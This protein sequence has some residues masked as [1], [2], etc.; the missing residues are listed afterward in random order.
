M[1][2]SSAAAGTTDIGA[3]DAYL[4]PADVTKHTNLVNI[5][6][7]VAALMVIYHVPGVSP[8]THLRLNGKV[9]AQIFAGTIT[10][11]NDPAIRNLNPGS[12][13]RAP[14]SC[15]STGPTP[16]AARSCSPRT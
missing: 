10:T 7:A 6:L 8:S 13:C 11:W 15:S 9:L 4:S 1:G 14:R 12:P 5:P 3:S 2:I 16:R